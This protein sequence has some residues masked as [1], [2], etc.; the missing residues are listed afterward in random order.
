M[1]LN[2]YFDNAGTE[3]QKGTLKFGICVCFVGIFYIRDWCLRFCYVQRIVVGLHYSKHDGY[4]GIQNTC[5]LS[6][7]MLPILY[8]EVQYN[9]FIENMLY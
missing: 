5:I 4:F 7:A 2:I 6:C 3:Q 9:T 8:E 1:W